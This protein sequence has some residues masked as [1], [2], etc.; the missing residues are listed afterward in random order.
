MSRVEDPVISDLRTYHQPLPLL[1]KQAT[2]QQKLSKEREDSLTV[3]ALFPVTYIWLL[4][5][6]KKQPLREYR[7]SHPFACTAG[8]RAAFIIVLCAQQ[9][10][11]DQ[12]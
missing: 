7:D 8:L 11:Y 9:L 10:H 3:R 1:E 2:S 12:M 5:Q 4:G 6:G